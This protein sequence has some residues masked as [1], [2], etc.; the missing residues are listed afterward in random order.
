MIPEFTIRRANVEE[1]EAAMEL[2][3]KTFLKFEAPVYSQEGSDNFLNFIS[4]EK[5]YQMFL[6]GEY[7]VWVALADEKIVGVGSLRAGS[8]ISLL[9]VDEEY[10]LKG[11]GKALVRVMQ[12]HCE[13][14]GSVKLTVNASPYGEAF[15]HKLGFMDAKEQ[16][17]TD[18]ILYTPMML[19]EKI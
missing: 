6:I 16:Q 5:L 2:V 18:G 9:F 15:Y 4:G 12:E 1:W 7:L 17:Q 14:Q 3:W 10:Q 8:H 13:E 11:I 19:L